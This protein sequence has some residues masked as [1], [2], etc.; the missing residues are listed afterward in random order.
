MCKEIFGLMGALG[1]SAS[2]SAL[3]AATS[4]ALSA[5]TTAILKTAATAAAGGVVVGIPTY[6]WG[7]RCER[8][9]QYDLGLAICGLTHEEKDG[10]LSKSEAA[11]AEV[12]TLL[13]QAAAGTKLAG[14][15]LTHT[16][17][18]RGQPEK[19]VVQDNELSQLKA[20][21]AQLKAALVAKQ[22]STPRAPAQAPSAQAPSAPAFDIGGFMQ[23]IV[24]A[25]PAIKV[26]VAELRSAVEPPPV[27]GSP[28]TLV[29]PT[30]E[31]T[32]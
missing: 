24:A 18:R 30:T 5:G 4:L 12:A 14:G 15:K 28:L 13:A 26:I 2:S 29:P 23:G 31:P 20:E 17:F 21:L 9:N 19:V 22:Q 8:N 32:K 25:L 16:P 7:V 3:G 10:C 11:D 1:A 27:S 6:Y